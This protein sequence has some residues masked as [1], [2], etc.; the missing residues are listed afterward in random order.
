VKDLLR[1][2][3]VGAFELDPPLAVEVGAGDDWNEAKS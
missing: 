2:E 3:M 1:A